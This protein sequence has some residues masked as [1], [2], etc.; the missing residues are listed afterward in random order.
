MRYDFN[1]TDLIDEEL[2]R[3]AQAADDLAFTELMSRY[4]HRIKYATH[5][6]SA[7]KCCSAVLKMYRNFIPRRKISSNIGAHK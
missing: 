5:S 7:M 6:T 4:S 2:I 1:Y 3:L